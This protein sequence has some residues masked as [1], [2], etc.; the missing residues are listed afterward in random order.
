MGF[1]KVTRDNGKYY[2]QVRTFDGQTEVT[3]YETPEYLTA[4]MAYADAKCWKAFHMTDSKQDNDYSISEDDTIFEAGSKMNTSKVI[5]LI[6]K[7]AD[8]ECKVGPLTGLMTGLPG[9]TLAVR[10]GR[11][12][13]TMR[14]TWRTF[15]IRKVSK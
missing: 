3:H 7:H 4:E 8:S 14:G 1:V 2:A 5:E 9:F 12:G 10:V 6:A 15:T 11:K 13:S